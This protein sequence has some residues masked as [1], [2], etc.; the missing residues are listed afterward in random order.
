MSQGSVFAL[1]LV[2]V[3]LIAGCSEPPASDDAPPH[4][5]PVGA[6][7]SVF[8]SDLSPE[9]QTHVRGLLEA[10]E[11]EK[12]ERDGCATHIVFLVSA[13]NQYGEDGWA[14][15]EAEVSNPETIRFARAWLPQPSEPGAKR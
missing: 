8:R 7:L 9:A 14:F 11:D 12:K 3:V 2:V 15:A 10:I 1:L 4:S 6:G 13:L 5:E